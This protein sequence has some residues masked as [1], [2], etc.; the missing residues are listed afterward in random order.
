[1][2]VQA[3][4]CAFAIR[5]ISASEKL[6][7]LALA[8]YANEKMQCWPSQETLA[9]DTELGAR[10]VWGALKVLEEHRILSRISRKRADGTR[11]T[12]V[13]TLHFAGTVS[14]QPVANPAKSDRKSCEIKSQDLPNQVAT[15]ATLTTLEPSVREPVRANAP[16]ADAGDY[17]QDAFDVWYAGYPHKVGRQAADTAFRHAR[18][19]TGPHRGEPKP[20]FATLITGRDRYVRDKPPDRSWCNPAT[21]L[22]Q[23]RWNDQ[24]AP[25]LTLV[26]S[27]ERADPQT[28]KFAAQQANL[29]RA[30]AG[31]EIAAGDR[32]R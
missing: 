23:G 12:D 29:A 2:S 4:S 15:V 14:A 5:G 11:S 18:Y 32:E 6:V 24:P 26:K 9:E 22:N 8:N 28:A 1:M 20:T 17:P 21:W 16:I 19:S 25:V 7:L 31:S 27:H 13:F 3:L 10:T 30:F